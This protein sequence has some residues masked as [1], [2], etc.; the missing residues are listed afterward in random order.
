[1]SHRIGIL[2]GACAAA[3]IALALPAHTAQPGGIEQAVEELGQLN[4]LALACRQGALTAR[5][6]ELLIEVAPKERAIGEHFERATQEAY[7]EIGRSGGECPDGRTLAA[8][9]DAAREA[10]LHAVRQ[11]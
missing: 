3:L 2:T 7:L 6:R 4:G 5:V 1:M 8:Q 11:P 9:I 10:L